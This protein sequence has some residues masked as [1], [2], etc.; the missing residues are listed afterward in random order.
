MATYA[1]QHSVLEGMTNFN[2]SNCNIQSE[3]LNFENNTMIIPMPAAETSSKTASA[4]AQHTAIFGPTRI[5]VINGFFVGTPQEIGDF[6]QEIDDWQNDGNPTEKTYTNS[7]GKTY[8]GRFIPFSYSD[9]YT[10]QATLLIDF[11]LTIVEG[12]KIT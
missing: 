2:S 10:T 12:T 1:L 9:N 4:Q 8:E 7:F 5:I 11:T 3:R 6:R